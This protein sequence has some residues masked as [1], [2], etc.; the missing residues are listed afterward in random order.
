MLSHIPHSYDDRPSTWVRHHEQCGLENLVENICE[1]MKIFICIRTSHHLAN[2]WQNAVSYTTLLWWQ[3][4]HMSKTSWAMWS[5]KFS[6]KY[7]WSNE[8]IYMNKQANTM[9]IKH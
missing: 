5:W 6:G 9:A 2:L 4:K 3:A 1:A 8:N 7:L